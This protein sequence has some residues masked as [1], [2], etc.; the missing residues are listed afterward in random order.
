[1]MPAATAERCAMMMKALTGLLLGALLLGPLPAA[2]EDA[3]S[4]KQREAI[5]RIIHDYIVKHPEVLIEAMQAAEEREKSQG[6]AR[7]QDA[8]VTRRA[9]L[10]DDPAAP[11]G[12]NPKGNVIL[13]EFFDY[14]CPY[15]KEVEPALEQ[16]LREDGNIRLV[17]KEWPILGKPSV[18]ASRM[19][20]AAKKQGKYDAFHKAMMAAK[21][22]IDEEVV[23]K[24][25]TTVGV[26]LAKAKAQ[27]E[28]DDIDALIKRNYS[29]ADALDIHGTPAFVIGNEIIPGAVDVSVL[30][31]KIAAARKG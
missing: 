8:L 19:A 9:E 21:G 22:Q 3:I 6:A 16:M 18:Y 31:A 20:L 25:A 11:I 23:Q 1:M 14:R 10:L 2:A 28:D 12:G 26:D 4:P 13:V 27:M 24:V 30:K 17:Y 29:L 15:C 5:E 7:A